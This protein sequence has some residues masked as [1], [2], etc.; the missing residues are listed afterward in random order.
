MTSTSSDCIVRDPRY[1]VPQGGV[2]TVHVILEGEDPVDAQVV[3]LTLGGAK[4]LMSTQLTIN[5]SLELRI[6]LP[7]DETSI[8]VSAKVCWTR[9]LGEEQW[10]IGCY[11]DPPIP[12]SA[13]E[14]LSVSG[15]L[16][17]RRFDRF[18]TSIE[19]RARWEL[20]QISVPV[21]IINVS[22]GGFCART[23]ETGEPGQ[24]MLIEID[25]GDQGTLVI[26]AKLHWRRKIDDGYHLGCAFITKDGFGLLQ[27]IAR[28]PEDPDE[29]GLLRPL[30]TRRWTWMGLLFSLLWFG[31]TAV[32]GLWMKPW[33]FG[34]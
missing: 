7:C 23:E 17:R 24:R 11:F 27:Y 2:V 33:S 1:T 8:R 25:R 19:A 15:Y 31:M 20:S 21:T 34:Q 10:W 18:E 26:P 16:E 28:P 12:D 3:D 14:S 4:L 6:N 13:I 29:D 30:C 22:A 32:V 5:Q 9:P